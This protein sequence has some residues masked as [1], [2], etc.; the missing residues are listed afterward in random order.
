MVGGHNACKMCAL[1]NS[2]DLDA[3]CAAWA[4]GTLA[5]FASPLQL[6][7]NFCCT[8]WRGCKCT[9]PSA[10]HTHLVQHHTTVHSRCFTRNACM[11]QLIRSAG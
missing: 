1:V 3:C 6:F 2:D 10:M 7:C 8:L 11:Y 9:H 4:Y 5:S